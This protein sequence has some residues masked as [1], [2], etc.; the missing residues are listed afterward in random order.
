MTRRAKSKAIAFFRSV[1]LGLSLMLGLA[2]TTGA[3]GCNVQCNGES[4]T[5][6]EVGDEIEDAAE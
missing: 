6:E 1:V 3:E 2:V 5:A 4:E